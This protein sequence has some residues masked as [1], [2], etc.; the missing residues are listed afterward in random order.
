MLA[1]TTRRLL[2][3]IPT[4]L[5]V[6]LFVFVLFGMIPGSAITAGNVDQLDPVMV[7]RLRQEFGLDQPLYMRYAE[8][9]GNLASGDFGTSLTTRQPVSDLLL[10][11]IW[12]SL[13]LAIFAMMIAIAVGVPLGFV[14]GIKRGSWVDTAATVVAVSG[15]S[16]PQFWLGL[17]LMYL[18]AVTLNWLPA[19]GYGDGGLRYLILP[20]ISLGFAFMALLARTT[21]TAVVEILHA[22]YIRTANAKGLSRLAVYGKHVLRNAM[23][24]IVTTAGLQFGAIMGKSV[25]IEKLFGWQ[26]VGAL[27]LDSIVGRD[28]PTAQACIVVMILFFILVNLAVDLLYRVI[29]PRVEYK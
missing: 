3:L 21:R 17:L 12:P 15:T 9:V 20:A 18:F 4:V 11:R 10:P 13:K 1:Y 19:S 22:D 27:L 16:M 26:G 8:F 7:E 28:L 25:I 23:M 6:S 29:D 14:A 5:V 24:L 2:Q